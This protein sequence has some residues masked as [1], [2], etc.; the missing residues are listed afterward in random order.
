MMTQSMKSQGEL[1]NLS[2]RMDALERQVS[3]LITMKSWLVKN[4]G[5]LFQIDGDKRAS[6]SSRPTHPLPKHDVARP[7][8]VV[9][10]GL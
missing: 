7:M 5:R 6:S 3:L 8:V 9:D 1:R 2:H 4:H 10:D